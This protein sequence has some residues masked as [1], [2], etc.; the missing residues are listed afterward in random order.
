VPLGDIIAQVGAIFECA[1][2][3]VAAGAQHILPPNRQSCQLLTF[4]QPSGPTTELPRQS[5]DLRLRTRALWIIWHCQRRKQ[6]SSPKKN[7]RDD[8]KD[9]DNR[10]GWSRNG[11]EGLQARSESPAAACGYGM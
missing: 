10:Q 7:G 9:L 5:V 2:R 4:A 11:S 6:R 1:G 3:R 8:K